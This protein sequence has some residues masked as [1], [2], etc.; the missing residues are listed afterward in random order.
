MNSTFSEKDE[1]LNNEDA[2]L[3]YRRRKDEEKNSVSYGQRK[4]F[5]ALL[6]FI[7]KHCLSETKKVSGNKK[8][9]IVYAGAAPGTNIGII[10]DLFPQFIFHLYDPSKFKVKATNRI[11]IYQKKFTDKVANY[12]KG[13]NEKF[14]NVIFISDIRTADYT[15]VEKLEENEEQI[16]GDMNMQ[17]RW[18]EIIKPLKTQLKFRLPYTGCGFNDEIEYFDGIIYKQFFAPQT[19]TETRL[20]LTF[21]EL[22]YKNYSCEK[23]QSQLFY[24]NVITREQTKYEEDI[25]DGKE[26]VNDYDCCG[27]IMLWKEY[28]KS[29]NYEGDFKN[30]IQELSSNVT[31]LLSRGKK[32][33][34]TLSYLRAHPRAIKDRNFNRT[35][36]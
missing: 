4:L 22:K 1:I 33:K 6:S 16:M 5:L 19:S 26:L 25:C 12:W 10:S 9:N 30:K 23:Y 31:D 7:T 17:R 36:K 18:V 35:A 13:Q 21:P 32:Q 11:F 14:K 2:Q 15:K 29:I 3:S 20:V 24:H 8:I 34:D 28:L 27:E